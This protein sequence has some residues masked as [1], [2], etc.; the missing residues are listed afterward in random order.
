MNLDDSLVQIQ[1]MQQRVAQMLSTV[2]ATPSQQQQLESI[3]TS[4][5]E[6][7]IAKVEPQVVNK[8]LNSSSSDRFQ[9]VATAL[10]C[11]IYDWDIENRTV[12]RTQGLFDV[13]G[14]RPDEVE[15]TLSWWTQRIDSGDRERVRNAVKHALTN[16]TNFGIEYRVLHKDERYRYVRDKGLI[17]RNAE[18]KVVC[19]LGIT[20]D[21]TERKQVEEAFKETTQRLQTAITNAPI[22]LFALDSEGVFTLSEGRTLE[23][24]GKKPNESVGQSV[25]DLYRDNPN[26]LENMRRTLA[27]VE[28]TWI[29]EVGDLVYEN[30]T[31]PLRD[32]NGQVIGLIGVATD[33]TERIRAQEALQRLNEELENRVRQRTES[34]Q[35]QGRQLQN[36]IAERQQTLNALRLSEELFRQLAE[37]IHQVFW[38]KTPDQSQILYISPAYEQIWGRTCASL[39]EQPKSWMDTIHPD[40]RNRT[41][42]ILS[43]RSREAR[44]GE[45]RIVRPD[46]SIRWIQFQTF[47]VRDEAGQVYR[48]VGIA[49]DIS[50]R[51]QAE[52]ALNRREQEF[53]ALVENA[54]DVIARFD[55]QLRY[56]YVNPAFEQVT[57][58]S[59]EAS[60][61]KTFQEL[62]MPSE[63]A[64]FWSQEI[65]RV[66]ETGS[67]Q[68]IEFDF[69]TSSGLKHYQSHLVPEFSV[70][71]SVES[72]LG[73]SR[74]IT[75]L[76]QAEEALRRRGQEF[77]ALVEN[78][79]DV[80]ARLDRQLR[81]LYVNPAIEKETGIS[82][83]AYIGK[84][85]QEL[86]MP[87]ELATFWSQEIFRVFETGSEQE[88]E[89]SY[90][91]PNG[92]RYHL[93]RL[94]PEFSVDGSIETVLTI[95]RDITRLKQAEE[96][97]RESEKRFRQ[98]AENINQ[99]FWISS[100]DLGQ[101]LY[102]SPAYEEIWGKSREHLYE[103]PMSY[104]DAL[105]PEDRE[106]VIAA[107]ERQAINGMDEEY[108]I[109]RPD[110]SIRWIRDRSFPV[111]D[112]QGRIYRLAGI[113]EDITQQKLI[114]AELE[115][116]IQRERELNELRSR[117][118][119]MTSHEF[120]NPLT[121]ISTSAQ[122]LER[123]GNKFSQE[124]QR[125][126][127]H[128]IQAA[129]KQMIQLLDDVLL[130][131]KAEAGRMKCN[132]T[133]IDLV[134]F[135]CDL[136]EQ[137]QL[138]DKNQHNVA[139]THQGDCTKAAQ[140][141]SEGESKE[142]DQSL[143]LLDEK[144]LQHILGNLLSNAIKYSPSGSTVR[145]DLTC[146]SD[147]AIFQ[148]QDQGIGIPP[149]DQSR[150]F[151]AFHRANNVGKIKGTGLGLA[152]V[153]Q[154]VDLHRGQISV[155]SVVGSGTTFTV[156]LPLNYSE[157]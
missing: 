152:I 110:G 147:Q 1:D 122:L 23:S 31:T 80:I 98:L 4:F 41:T 49:E 95:G 118:I 63:L 28:G 62:G 107:T 69:L 115:K 90:P 67:K 144:L 68:Q 27:G 17:V 135:C 154:C 60:S 48:F 38:V 81:H 50:D 87:S 112:K 148:I 137:L 128:R 109:L 93:S 138:A 86:G 72:V 76:K 65:S 120:R 125:S 18:G 51:K 129:V 10:D 88:I 140:G 59:P 139:F 22:I 117:F 127:L 13:L 146:L 116:G 66:F 157:S 79:P 114:E 19:V 36:E 7:C 43:N 92:L 15:P 104:I 14:Y 8:K 29:G 71:G 133:P 44:Q 25:F 100:L 56:V 113:A 58:I 57:G 75:K 143:P 16:S 20:I 124:N 9:L 131:G 83:E 37:N 5:Q 119:S 106:H 89:F 108:R 97:L 111:S 6:L 77:R 96:K 64:L 70:D 105:H 30:R 52:E 150:L 99:V 2:R 61:G 156:T 55:R 141:T 130:I 74:D 145:F 84:T 26:I 45:Y 32:E 40:D 151:E 132:P 94:V 101:I 33:I 82:P 102:I 73:I 126:Y 21:I 24:L 3:T 35:Q 136:V 46:G 11:I 123:Y 149:E 142:F 12:D 53:R 103:N 153:K 47:P 155:E 78:A 54:P 42:T 121:T 39:Y 85:F 134:Q 34:L 91:T